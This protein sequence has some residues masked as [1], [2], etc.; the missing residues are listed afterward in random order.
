MNS[1][2]GESS[3]SSSEPVRPFPSQFTS[4][5]PFDVEQSRV[6]NLVKSGKI[7][8]AQREFD[9][10]AWQAFIA[11]NWPATGNG[12][13]DTTKTPADST[14]PRVW[15]FWR[16]AGTIF[17]PNGDTPLPWKAPASLP[18]ALPL[19][20]AKAAWRQTST[21]AD[22]N[23]Q[24]FSGPLVD[25]NGKWVRYEVLVNREEFDYFVN[26]ALYSLDG[27]IAFSQREDSN[28]IHLPFNDSDQKQRGAIE[29][30]LAWKELGPNDD[31]TRFYTTHRKVNVAE[32]YRA[33]QTE[34]QTKEIEVGLVGMHIAMPTRSSPEW[35]W[36]TFE[37]IDNVRV[38]RDAKGKSAHPNFF[39]PTQ[40]QA[41]NVLPAKNA[42]IDPKTNQPVIVHDDTPAKPEPTT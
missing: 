23:F 38:N 1:I 18:S 8:A 24:A 27:Q 28:E 34:P 4:E 9:I 41:V 29:I 3:S 10:L 26:N 32:P 35:I 2:A 22:Q 6:R 21:S 7:I 14:S 17:L 12:Q 33:G 40:P 13:P 30:K 5:L 15:S 36:A 25:Q 16:P 31:H 19:F 39:S 37:Q 20:R 42:I 11:L